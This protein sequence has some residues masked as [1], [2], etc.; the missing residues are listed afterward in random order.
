MSSLTK[1]QKLMLNSLPLQGADKEHAVFKHVI[2]R[3]AEK[4][5]THDMYLTRKI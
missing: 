3:N 1:K 2:L 4:N 5:K